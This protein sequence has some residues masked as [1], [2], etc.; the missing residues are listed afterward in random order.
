MFADITKNN[1]EQ[2]NCAEKIEFK[3]TERSKLNGCLK[4]SKNGSSKLCL[5]ENLEV[6]NTK[7]AYS[8]EGKMKQGWSKKT[9]E[10]EPFGVLDNQGAEIM[11]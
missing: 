1:K 3:K 4:K 5:I 9:K 2:K 7:K 6:R 8:K 10:S 11:N